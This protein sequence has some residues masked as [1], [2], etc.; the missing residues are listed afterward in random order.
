MCATVCAMR[1]L[2]ED[3]SQERNLSVFPYV[4]LSSALPEPGQV[5]LVRRPVRTEHY[6]NIKKMLNGKTMCRLL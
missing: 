3:R 5:F 4:S 2:R 1:T 6:E